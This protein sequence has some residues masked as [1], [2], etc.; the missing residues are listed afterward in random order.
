M[1]FSEKLMELRKLRGWS[2]EELGNKLDVSRQTVSKW[3]T[4]VT[5]PELEKLMELGRIFDISLDE[6]TGLSEPQAKSSE[7]DN[8]PIPPVPYRYHFEYKSKRTLFGLPL[9][10]IHFGRGLCRAKGILAIGNIAQGVVAVGA[11]AMGGIALGAL[12]VG[13]FAL[14]ALA[15]ALLAVGGVAVGGIAVGGL[16]VG[17][18]AI[19]GLAVGIYALG[20]C[21]IASKIAGGGYAQGHVAIGEITRGMV[22]LHKDAGLTPSQIES[23]IYEAFPHTVS[24]I[25][26]LFSALGV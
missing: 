1:N 24:F 21:A 19:G 10:H 11:L 8:I 2:Q 16:A 12:S 9:F 17:L 5:T 23:V 25:A 13:V 18:L 4:G 6:L 26:K 15:V 20:G 3:E 7:P 22:R 14:G